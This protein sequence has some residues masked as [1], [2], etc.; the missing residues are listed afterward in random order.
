MFFVASVFV[1]RK[2]N[3]IADSNKLFVAAQN[4]KLKEEKQGIENYKAECENFLN[5]KSRDEK[6]KMDKEIKRNEVLLYAIKESSLVLAD[7]HIRFEKI[8]G[9]FIRTMNVDPVEI[10]SLVTDSVN[11]RNDIETDFFKLFGCTTNAY[12]KGKI[13]LN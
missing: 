8:M 9:K 1:R 7:H 10:N 13:R 11:Y 3:I 5:R 2:N 12:K 6:E 4:E